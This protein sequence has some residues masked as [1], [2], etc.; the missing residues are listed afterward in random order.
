MEDHAQ[1]TDDKTGELSADIVDA[2]LKFLLLSPEDKEQ[3][4]DLIESLKNN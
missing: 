3:V 2:A 4:M 1:I